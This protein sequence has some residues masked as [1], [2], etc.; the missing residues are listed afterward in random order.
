[1]LEDES[2]ADFDGWIEE[3]GAIWGLHP[4]VG[5]KVP[6]PALPGIKAVMCITMTLQ[7]C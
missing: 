3:D 1:M 2:D 6:Q 5:C 4:R 7:T